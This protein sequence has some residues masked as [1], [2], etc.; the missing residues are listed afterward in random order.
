MDR[1]IEYAI[2]LRETR[3]ATTMAGEARSMAS[4]TERLIQDI[5]VSRDQVE[6]PS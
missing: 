1:G 4:D 2:V 6:A 5:H 3:R